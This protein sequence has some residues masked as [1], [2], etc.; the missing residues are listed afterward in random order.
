VLRSCP[1]PI[2]ALVAAALVG[3]VLAGCP[4]DEFEGPVTGIYAEVDDTIASLV[5]VRWEQLEAATGYVQY[6]IDGE[7][8]RQTP[9][10]A[11]EP[12]YPNQILLGLPYDTDV[13]YSLVM[14]TGGGSVHSEIQTI[15]TGEIPPGVPQPEVLVADPDAW[16]PSFEFLLASLDAGD[17]TVRFWTHIFDRQG[18]V[19]WAFPTEPIRS[20]L[21]TQPAVDGRSL[22]IDANSYWGLFDDGAASVINRVTLDGTVQEVIETPGLHH[23]FTELPDGSLAWGASDDLNETLDVLRPDGTIETLWDCAD[24]QEDVGLSSWCSSNT[25]WFDEA[26]NRFLFSFFSLETVVEIDAASGAVTRT[27]GKAPGSWAFDPP[28]SSFRWQHGTVFT[29]EGTLLVSCRL[30]GE[31]VEESETVVREYSLDPGSE[32][33]S[34][35]W[36]FGVGDGIYGDMMGEAHRLPNGNTLHNTGTAVRVRETTPDGTVVWDI[37][38]DRGSFLGRTTPL[39]ELYAFLP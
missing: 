35:I 6:A 36:S 11:H 4:E 9:A 19:V 3:G 27:F 33:L 2:L 13:T 17:V 32:T 21:H 1:V 30:D 8:P 29:D 15:R 10:T 28:E 38:W 16:D 12:G 22:L 18:R 20:T 24:F 34:Q 37:T 5:T 26:A 39:E 14:D 25:L 23:P 31:T 7:D